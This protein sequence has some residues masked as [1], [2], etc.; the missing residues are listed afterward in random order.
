MLQ[1]GSAVFGYPAGLF[2][3]V[4]V[5]EENLLKPCFSRNFI[6]R[7]KAPRRNRGASES[8]A[9]YQFT[10]EVELQRELHQSRIADLERLTEC[11]ALIAHVAIHAKE[12]R[13]VPDVENIGAEFH[14][15]SLA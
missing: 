6:E 8:F 9:I 15:Q 14:A 11:G 7:A 2:P 5:C 3:A 4:S 10:L 13:V 12:L 1:G